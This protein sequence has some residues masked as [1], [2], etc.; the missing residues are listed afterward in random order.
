MR[1]SLLVQ[2]PVGE[3]QADQICPNVSLVINKENFTATLIVLES[4]KIR[5][6]L[7]LNNTVREKN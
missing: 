6:V 5:V 7:G 4:L 3:M 2:T 1:R